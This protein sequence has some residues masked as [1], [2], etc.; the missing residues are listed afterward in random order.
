MTETG[1]ES[2]GNGKSRLYEEDLYS[3]FDVVERELDDDLE[4]TPALAE[5]VRASQLARR[6][7]S[8]STAVR[9][10]PSMRRSTERVFGSRQLGV[11]DP[12]GHSGPPL[13]AIHR[14]GYSSVGGHVS[15]PAYHRRRSSVSFKGHDIFAR[16]ICIKNFKKCPNFT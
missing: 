11:F 8:S 2:N 14:A 1:R 13:T 9:Q 16:K 12:E 3:D 10:A 15:I 7:T 4:R 6:V 5:A